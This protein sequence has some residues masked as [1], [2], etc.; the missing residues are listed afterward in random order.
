MSKKAFRV[1]MIPE[2]LYYPITIELYRAISRKIDEGD[3]LAR[4]LVEWYLKYVGI[5]GQSLV[6]KLNQKE[7]VVQ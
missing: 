5:S 2:E 3:K 7:A 4:E 6:E 1:L